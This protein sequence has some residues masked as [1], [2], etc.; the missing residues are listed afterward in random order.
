MAQFLGLA[1]NFLFDLK[2]KAVQ[3]DTCRHRGLC[4]LAVG[5][6]VPPRAGQGRQVVRRRKEKEGRRGKTGSE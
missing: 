3:T 1:G 4:C 5:T 6:C 2:L